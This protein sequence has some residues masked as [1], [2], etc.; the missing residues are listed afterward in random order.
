MFSGLALRFRGRL[1]V[2]FLQVLGC[3]LDLRQ[4]GRGDRQPA[5]LVR[6]P[7]RKLFSILPGLVLLAGLLLQRLRIL[8]AGLLHG[9]RQAIFLV[10]QFPGPL[11]ELLQTFHQVGPRRFED[12]W[13][14]VENV[15]KILG[16]LLLLLLERRALCLKFLLRRRLLLR[17]LTVLL[18]LTRLILPPRRLFRGSFRLRQLAAL[19][20]KVRDVPRQPLRLV[21][22]AIQ[23]QE[24]LFELGQFL[25]PLFGL[26]QLLRRFGQFLFRLLKRGGAA[27]GGGIARLLRFLDGRGHV[28]FRNLVQLRTQVSHHPF[29]L[30]LGRRLLDPFLEL[31]F[32]DRQ[33]VG[34][35]LEG[36]LFDPLLLRF[37][38]LQLERRRFFF[39]G[40][41]LLPERGEL[42]ADPLMPL[43]QFARPECGRV[44]GDRNHALAG[45]GFVRSGDGPFIGRAGLHGHQ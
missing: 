33:L 23:L 18:I 10:R 22:D 29:A 40:R 34:L 16:Q 5:L 43:V 41:R 38:R 8:L 25:E 6:E 13:P 15:L 20:F 45:P 2:P 42:I 1:R 7:G 35:T 30:E 4:V 17:S 36:L 44:P 31:L 26:G 24:I 14:A 32:T 12:L 3:F 28:L 19:L 37:P 11:A 27:L 21:R 39:A 9:L